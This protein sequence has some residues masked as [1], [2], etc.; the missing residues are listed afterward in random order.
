MKIKLEKFTQADFPYYFQLV[1]NIRVMAMITERALGLEEAKSKYEKLLENNELEPEFGSF[2]VL[3]YDTDEFLGFAKLEVKAKN[4]EEAEL[5]Y[6]LLPEYWGQGIASTIAKKLIDI[7]DRHSSLMRITAVI[8]P[9][10]IP[11]RRILTKN[12]F[13]TKGYRDFDGLHGEILE[14]KI[15]TV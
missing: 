9:N 11:S 5:G 14:L 12:G 8:D 10:N 1:S 4:P 6:M 7:S 13:E 3:Q 15:R 2:K